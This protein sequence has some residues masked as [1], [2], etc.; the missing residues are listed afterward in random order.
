MLTVLFADWYGLSSC[1]RLR[2]LLMCLG[3]CN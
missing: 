2:A 3:S 1:L